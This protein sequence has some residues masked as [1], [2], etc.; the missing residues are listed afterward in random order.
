MK[1]PPSRLTEAAD[2]T[3][4]FMPNAESIAIAEQGK[5]I[6]RFSSAEDF[7]TFV[8]RALAAEQERDALRALLVRIERSCAAKRHTIRVASG[9]L[10]SVYDM[11]GGTMRELRAALS[12]SQ[13]EQTV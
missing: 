13:K 11:D 8:K 7:V 9:E 12:A 3:G 1:T 6:A 4:I 2:D 5:E 10:Q